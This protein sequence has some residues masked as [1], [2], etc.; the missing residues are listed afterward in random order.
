MAV[1]PPEGVKALVFFSC[2][3]SGRSGGVGDVFETVPFIL[4]SMLLLVLLRSCALVL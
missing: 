2:R 4:P 3:L 1:L